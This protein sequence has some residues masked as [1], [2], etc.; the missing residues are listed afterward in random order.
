MKPEGRKKVTAKWKRDTH[1]RKGYM[2]WWE[3]ITDLMPRN[4]RKQNWKKEIEL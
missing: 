3:V 2:N 4:V 1:P